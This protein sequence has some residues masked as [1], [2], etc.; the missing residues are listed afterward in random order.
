MAI[1]LDGS[2]MKAYEYLQMLGEYAHWEQ[3]KRDSLWE[4]FLKKQKL[5]EEFVFYLENHELQ[6]TVNVCGITLLDVYVWQMEQYNL[7]HDIGKNTGTCNK[8][9]LVLE[10][11][12]VMADL[13]ER[14]DYY[15][16][17]MSQGSGMDLLG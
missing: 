1:I 4:Y 14:P 17:K 10:S 11:F 2:K 6:G 3:E 16:K 8:E 7:Y 15:K 13:M 12:Y 9:R 5:Y